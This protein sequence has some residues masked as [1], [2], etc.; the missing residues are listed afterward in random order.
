MTDKNNLNLEIYEFILNEY[1][2]SPSTGLDNMF[3]ST[4]TR[5]IPPENCGYIGKEEIPA[6][7]KPVSDKYVRSCDSID[8]TIKNMR[9]T[10]GDK[11]VLIIG[12][13]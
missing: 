4:K 1:S 13:Q 12:M 9:T 5:F 8:G 2:G 7:Q 11:P 3:Y 10:V 6:H